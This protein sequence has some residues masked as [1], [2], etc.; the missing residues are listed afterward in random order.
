MQIR[1]IQE[2]KT[3]FSPLCVLLLC[4]ILFP[5]EVVEEVTHSGYLSI[6][7]AKD[8]IRFP[9]NDT[10]SNSSNSSNSSSSS[11]SLLASLLFASPALFDDGWQR[12]YVVLHRRSLLLMYKDHRAFLFHPGKPLNLRPLEL[13]NNYKL[14]VGGGVGGSPFLLSLVP[15]T[16]AEKLKL[17]EAGRE[18]NSVDWELEEEEEKALERRTWRF[19]CDTAAQFES[20]LRAFSHVIGDR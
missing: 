4:L 9:S 3:V 15:L 6:F 14:E 2:E 20:W 11:S 5:E 12:Q 13:K 1:Q 19:R 10:N 18:E 17:S 16:A 7:I 8:S